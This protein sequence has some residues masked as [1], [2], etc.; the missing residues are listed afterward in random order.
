M[1]RT[2]LLLRL[3]GYVEHYNEIRLNSAIGYITPKDMLASH[4]QEI[5][6]ERDQKL[7]ATTATPSTGSGSTEAELGAQVMTA[8]V[9]CRPA[10]GREL[11]K[12]FDHPSPAP[13]SKA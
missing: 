10:A 13:S 11:I 2:A 9:T 12:V 4:Q 5:P 1:P 8:T 3:P 6:V 7:A